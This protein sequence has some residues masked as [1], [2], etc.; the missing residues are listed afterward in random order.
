MNRGFG[1]LP[2]FVF[3]Q[4]DTA[5]HVVRILPPLE[6]EADKGEPEACLVRNVACMNSAIEAV[7][8][9]APDHWM[10]PH[11]RFKT[12]PEGEVSPYPPRRTRSHRK[13]RSGV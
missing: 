2:V 7:I 5:R 6:L 3:R 1:V 9:Q 12:R 13:R 8:R 11:R 10:W 4:G